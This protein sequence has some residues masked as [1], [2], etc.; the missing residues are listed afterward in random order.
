MSLESSHHPTFHWDCFQSG[1]GEQQ[2]DQLREKYISQIFCFF[3]FLTDTTFRYCSFTAASFL[4]LQFL[5]LSSACPVS[6]FFFFVCF[7][8]QRHRASIKNMPGFRL[9]AC[10]EIPCWCKLYYQTALSHN[11]GLLKKRPMSKNPKPNKKNSKSLENFRW[12]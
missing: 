7:F 9:I 11:P 2:L 6:C 4:S 12:R 5:L 3:L 1:F 8:G 10:W